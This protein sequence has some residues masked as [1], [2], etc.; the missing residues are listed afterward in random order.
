MK[1]LDLLLKKESSKHTRKQLQTTLLALMQLLASF[2]LL[3]D[4]YSSYTQYF[5]LM[6][7]IE[8]SVILLFVLSYLL[9]PKHITFI[10]S[11]YLSL[12]SLAFLL[13]CSLIIPGQNHYFALFWLA[14]FPIY[15]FFFL[16]LQKGV[17]INALVAF[18]ILIC[19]LL[20]VTSIVKSLY[21]P[22]F[23]LQL[24]LGYLAIS[25][26]LYSL[27]KE[28]N[29]YEQLLN[30]TLEQKEVLLKEVHHRVKN[31]IQIIMAL[32]ETQSFK[33]EDPKYQKIFTNHTQR[34]KAMALIHEH[35]YK[36][37][38]YEYIHIDQYLQEI[39]N[40]TQ[41]FNN[42]I[43]HSDMQPIILDMKQATNLALVFNEALSNA[44]E[45]A[46]DTNTQGDIY[47]Q[48]H[49]HND[50]CV[51]RVRDEGKGFD[52]TKTYNTLG[53]TLMNN[54]STTLHETPI[55]ISTKNGTEV[56]IFCAIKRI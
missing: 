29:N 38:D 8:G 20:D 24:F 2:I 30:K 21:N 12:G 36:Q 16:G 41:T 10:Q 49:H 34:L 53:I 44:I 56:T 35:L 50:G 23:L 51:L 48:L 46:Y 47:V 17:V 19:A 1:F 11:T 43:I 28:R 4:L 31:N 22:D 37:H 33:L 13:I 52:T 15:S 55:Q 9:Y 40:Q 27:E 54:L 39:I 7:Y 32:L 3:L 42:H 6:S 26:L 5:Y 25:F 45:H 18:A 14:T